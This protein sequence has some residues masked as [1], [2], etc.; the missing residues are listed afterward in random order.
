MTPWQPMRCSLG[1]VLQFSRCLKVA[2]Q[3]LILPAERRFFIR[4]PSIWAHMLTIYPPIKICSNTDD[5]YC[6]PPPTPVWL[7]WAGVFSA[8][9]WPHLQR[10]LAPGPQRLPQLAAGQRA[11]EDAGAA[12]GAV[13]PHYGGGEQPAK[14]N[15][16]TQSHVNM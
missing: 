5:S 14:C 10:H 3:Y 16:S 11:P 12:G 4:D 7:C 2:K 1:S 15:L 13:E 9:D 8:G 6:T